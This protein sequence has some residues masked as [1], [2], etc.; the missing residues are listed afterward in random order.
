VFPQVPEV[1]FAGGGAVVAELT[2]RAITIGQAL[3]A[4]LVVV[5][6]RWFAELAG[7][8]AIGS[9][10]RSCTPGRPGREGRAPRWSPSWRQRSIRAYR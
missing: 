3:I 10:A 5:A 1:T 4:K 7:A 8:Q 9:P 6:E 2:R